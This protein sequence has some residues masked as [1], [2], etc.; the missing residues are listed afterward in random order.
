MAMLDCYK[1]LSLDKFHLKSHFRLARCLKDL[2]WYEEADECLALFCKYYP[3]YANSQAC[4]TLVKEVEDALAGP[5]TKEKK[6]SKQSDTSESDDDSS[7]SSSNSS[8]RRKKRKYNN[9]PNTNTD[10]NSNLDELSE[11]ERI[12]KHNINYLRAK[13]NAVDFKN[14][15]VGHCNV[16]TDIKEASFLGKD[17]I[18]A[19]SDDGNIFIWDK[20]T[21]NIVRVLKAD[22]SIVNCIQPH[23][24]DSILATSGIDADVKIWTP[25]L[26][27]D[28]LGE[29]ENERQVKDIKKA[30]INNQLQMNSHPFEFLLLNLAQNQN[31]KPI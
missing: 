12:I 24:F 2:K 16:S 29:V 19:G 23:P 15:Y 8:T 1:A 7:R 27:E 10:V 21:S 28:L 20:A 14:R 26:N 22:E 11:D 6:A 17:F 4:E 9:E 13:E 3:D 25:Q 31:G 18:C 30:A 5:K